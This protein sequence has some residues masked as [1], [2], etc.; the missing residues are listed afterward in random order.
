MNA[1]NWLEM[2]SSKDSGI[3]WSALDE[4][5]GSAVVPCSKSCSS[6]LNLELMAPRSSKLMSSLPLACFLQTNSVDLIRNLANR[7]FPS[8]V[9]WRFCFLMVS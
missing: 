7:S 2:H 1:C 6:W 9:V 4:M 3:S 8:V 5:L